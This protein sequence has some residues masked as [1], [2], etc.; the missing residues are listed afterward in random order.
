MDGGG[1]GSGVRRENGRGVVGGRVGGWGRAGESWAKREN[2]GGGGGG[3][4]KREWGQE[5]AGCEKRMREGA[6]QWGGGGG[7]ERY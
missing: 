7:G 6:G 2:G 4:E 3:G 1:Q 5:R